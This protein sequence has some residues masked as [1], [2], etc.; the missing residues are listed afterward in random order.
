[1]GQDGGKNPYIG[2]ISTSKTPLLLCTSIYFCLGMSCCQRCI[3]IPSS[4]LAPTLPLFLCSFFP[5]SFPLISFLF[6]FILL[7][8]LLPLL[9]PL[10]ISFIS[11]LLLYPL[12]KSIYLKMPM[13]RLLS[14]LYF[15]LLAR[16][17]AIGCIDL[18]LRERAMRPPIHETLVEIRETK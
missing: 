14:S 11:F 13:Q 6:H 15:P 17:V 18:I 5:S 12:L 1:M 8:F 16:K 9:L 7:H 3:L 4:Y 10:L 2:V